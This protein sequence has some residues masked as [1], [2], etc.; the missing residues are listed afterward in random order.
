VSL[1]VRPFKDKQGLKS[2][3]KA[4]NRERLHRVQVGGLRRGCREHLTGVQEEPNP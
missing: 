4:V 3:Q 2:S 1:K